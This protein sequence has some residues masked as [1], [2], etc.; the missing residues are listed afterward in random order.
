MSLGCISRITDGSRFD[1]LHALADSDEVF[2]VRFW[3][4]HHGAPSP[5]PSRVYSP[6][7]DIMKLDRGTL[8]KADRE[9]RSKLKT[10]RCPIAF[11]IQSSGVFCDVMI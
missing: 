3:M 1:V 6:M 8:K 9:S 5:K 11:N 2:E 4:M 7:G 10:S